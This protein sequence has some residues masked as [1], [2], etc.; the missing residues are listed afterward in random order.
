LVPEVEYD[1]ELQLHEIN[2]KMM[3]LI[4]QM[5]P[6]GPGNTV[7]IF[8]T[9]NVKAQNTAR[10]L[11]DKH[12]KLQ[13]SGNTRHTFDAIGFGLAEHFH[14]VSNGNIFNACYC[15]EENNYNGRVSVQLRL[16]DIKP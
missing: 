8:K 11:K 6:F 1:L 16:R 4:A 7:P 5:A 2:D 12:L 9:T 3:N 10:V 14:T 15:I 13:L